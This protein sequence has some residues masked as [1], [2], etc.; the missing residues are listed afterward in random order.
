MSRYINPVPQY[1]LN[2]GS[3]ASSGRL[4]FYE[5]KNYSLLKTTYSQSNN[6]IPNLNPL[7]LDGQGRVPACF[8]EGLYSVRLYAY[9]NAAIDKLG[10]LQWTRDD[11]VLSEI[12]GQFGVW[13]SNDVY[14]IGDISKGSDGKYYQS[15]AGNNKGFDPVST[16]SKWELIVFITAYNSSRIYQVG[17]T[18]FSGGNLYAS[19]TP[20][21]T[22]IAPPSAQ[23]NNLTLNNTVVGNLTVTGSA[24]AASFTS[25]GSFTGDN[26]IK[27]AKKTTDTNR[28]STITLAADPDLSIAVAA[29]TYYYFECVVRWQGQGSTTNGI[30]A[31]VTTSSG[32]T[33]TQIAIANANTTVANAAPTANDLVDSNLPISKLPNYSGATETLLLKGSILTTTAGVI[34]LDWSQAANVAVNTTVR[35]GSYLTVQKL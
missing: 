1:F 31:W 23:W 15:F 11:V 2:D 20:N 29:S 4:K 3:I 27:T 8:G 22:G 16:P 12:T 32:T 21:L 14:G 30:K 34:R 9:D 13:S 25:A 17:D 35:S 6:T 24:T 33:L 7:P 18:V 19:N 28:I 5:N 10:E 26:T